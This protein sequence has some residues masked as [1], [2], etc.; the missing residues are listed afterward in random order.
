MS[1][2]IAVIGA[3]SWGTALA[4]LLARKGYET[5]LWAH[6]A[7][8]VADLERQRENGTYLPGFAFPDTLHATGDLPEALTGVDCVLSVTPSHTVREVM[9]RALPHLPPGAPIVSAS[10]GI[11][12]STLMVMSEVLEDVLPKA[13]HPNLT[14]LS[15]PSFAKEVAQELPT[16]VTIAGHD[17]AFTRRAQELFTAPYFRA[18]T[19]EDVIGV[20]LGGALK[21]VMAIGAGVADGLGYGYNTRA[22]LITR[23]IAE[24]GRLAHK[25][26]ANPMTLAG[27]AGMGD[28]VLTCT[29]ELSRNRSV[30][31]RLGKGD[32]LATILGDMKMVAEG[33]KTSKSAYDLARRE[34]VEMPIVAEVYKI[35]YQ[36]KEPRLAVSELMGRLPKH[37]RAA[38]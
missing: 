10:K 4:L 33:V 15:G 9:T 18:Y 38:H 22:A 23:G 29:G 1:V 12:N 21:N 30:G 19:T 32:T 24:M 35:L 2:R 16:A 13:L 17:A 7:E 11:E 25:R 5:R 34:G 28:L 20:E 3:G 26:G 6:N 31:L 27:L 8:R 37:E 14:Y 36:D